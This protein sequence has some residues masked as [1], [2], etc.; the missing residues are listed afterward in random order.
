MAKP[1]AW[2]KKELEGP[3]CHDPCPEPKKRVTEGR[4]GHLCPKVCYPLLPCKSNGINR[5]KLK[6]FR[7]KLGYITLAECR[8]PFPDNCTL[9]PIP[10]CL[11]IVCIGGWHSQVS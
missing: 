3:K 2:A 9:M 10:N 1:G 11:L 6:G 8:S 7:V 5:K 4:K